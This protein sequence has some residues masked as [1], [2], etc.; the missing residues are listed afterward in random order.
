[1]R[2]LLVDH[3][4]RLFYVVLGVFSM[5]VL[6]IVGYA[7]VGTLVFGIFA[8]YATR[9]LYRHVVRHIGRPRISAAV[10]IVAFI[11]PFAALLWYT[12]LVALDEL[13]AFVETYEVAAIE[14]LLSTY[15]GDEI[16]YTQFADY[17]RDASNT[18]QVANTVLSYVSIVGTFLINAL[19]VATFTYYA[20]KDGSR[21]RSELNSM[22]PDDDRLRNFVEA[23]DQDLQTLFFGN[24][25]H[26]GLTGIIGAVTYTLL[27]LVAP[28]ELS[29]PYPVLAGMGAGAA[30]LIPVI[31]MKIV[32]VPMAGFIGWMSY[33]TGPETYWFPIAFAVVSLVIVDAIPDFIIRPY[34]S[35]DRLHLGALM[36][37]YIVGPF[38]FGWYGLFL[39]PLLL[40]VV[41]NFYTSILCD[42]YGAET[43]V[44]AE[45]GD[46]V[47]VRVDGDE[48][49]AVVEEPRL[50]DG[51]ERVQ[52]QYTGLV[53]GDD[54]RDNPKWAGRTGTVPWEDVDPD[55]DN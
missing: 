20:L 4:E 22:L 28:G 54:E 36:F 15:F 31:G 6:S 43:T 14:R 33:Q 19:L 52:V 51:G 44:P 46:E 18:G 13:E 11:L 32:Y 2:S 38:M 24:I 40:V 5:F 25:L 49:L 21:F 37:A 10:T 42:L 39:A 8:Y 48:R 30:S 50:G 41:T 3:P 26:A 35:G 34:V 53:D 16:E 55:A 17:L 23:V 12:G 7:Y 1:M 9:P 45:A 47:V 29:V 27:A